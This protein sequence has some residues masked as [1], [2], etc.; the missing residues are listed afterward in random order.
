MAELV[1]LVNRVIS[2]ARPGEQLEAFASWDR[3]LD[4]RVYD[5]A[6]EYLTQ[7]ESSGLGVRVVQGGRQGFAYAG[8]LEESVL[9]E[10]LQE[11]RDNLSFATPD[12]FVGLCKPDGVLP[13]P[14]ELWSDEVTSMAT[15]EKV[16]LALGLE[17]AI[18]SGDPRIS[19]VESSNYADVAWEAALSS[20]AGITVT[21]RGT[22]AYLSA[23]AI[24]EDGQDLR[25]GGGYSVGRSPGVLSV[26]E[27][28][29][30]TVVRATQLL[31]AQ[32]PPSGKVV[33][34]LDPRVSASVLSIIAGTLSGDAVEKGRSLFVGRLGEVVA[35]TR[36]N[37]I[38]DPTNPLAYLASSFDGEGLACRK[39]N[40]IENGVLMGYLYDSYSARRA[41]KD[42]TAS[43]SRAGFASTPGVGFR[44]ISLTP[45]NK[46]Q[47][48]IVSSIDRGLLVTSISGVH[49]GVNP[50]SGDFSVGAEGIMIE[51][52]Q[53]TRAVKEATIASSIQKML[54][55]IVDLGRDVEWLPGPSA[56]VAMAIS[57]MSMSGA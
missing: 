33:A 55:S 39:V 29:R 28:A 8:T 23:Y 16:D 50:I 11:A 37:L 35:D 7:A 49:S 38:E 42:S 34:V 20:T 10:V 18:K 56:G 31:G 36:V 57:D 15:Q 14:L 52:G 21:S 30:D 51:N 6:I 40:L 41:G 24:A 5:G 12:E 2:W 46:S 1:D 43:A 47:D 17:K 22:G 45:G 4:A 27:A 13:V 32:K 25:T 48:E 53:L 44:A 9:R 19:K 26:D 54:L 3:E